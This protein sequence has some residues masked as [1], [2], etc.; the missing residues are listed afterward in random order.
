MPLSILV[1]DDFEPWRRFVSSTLAKQSGL[2]TLFEVSDGLEAVYRAEDLRPDLILLD[3]GLPTLN[4]IEAARRIRD[5]SP[6][7]KILFLTEETSPDVAEAALEAGGAGYVVKSDAGRELLAAVK[8][9]SEGN[10]YV[11]ARLV[12]R[13]FF[14]A[15]AGHPSEAKSFHKL[16]VYPDDASFLDGFVSFIAGSLNAGN[17]IAVLAT[18]E[19][20]QGIFQKLETQGFDLGALVKSGG[21][22]P[23]DVAEALSLFIVDGKP[24]PNQF[25][26]IVSSLVETGSKAPNGATRRVFACG[27]CAPT[28]WR[29][30]K[31]D[32]AL[33]VEELWDEVSHK[34]GLSTLCGY[35]SRG[36]QGEREHGIFQRICAV[37]SAVIS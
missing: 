8:A 28:L 30:G 34:F 13:V 1:V 24:D 5:L 26:G 6:N 31:L 16:Q 3:I 18:E 32:D 9:L 37:H 2:Q 25:R 33:R 12:G 27:E 17:A 20:R 15:P 7:S 35:I 10:R 23:L 21:Y 29:Q 14:G 22:I 19:H 36:L 4:G 11:S